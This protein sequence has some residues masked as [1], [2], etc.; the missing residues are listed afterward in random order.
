VHQIPEQIRSEFILMA[1]GLPFDCRPPH[2]QPKNQLVR[3][4]KTPALQ[5]LGVFNQQRLQGFARKCLSSAA[6]GMV[7]LTKPSVRRLIT[8]AH[9]AEL[10]TWQ[11]AF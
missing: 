5:C 9:I 6:A 3:E 10:I 7:T 8:T 1:R 4:G 11:G 2:I